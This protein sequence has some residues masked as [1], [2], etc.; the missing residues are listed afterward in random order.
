MALIRI[1]TAIDAPTVIHANGPVYYPN[2]YEFRLMSDDKL[3]N[4]THFRVVNS[5]HNRFAF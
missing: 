5:P 4:E 2:G 1:D 3:L